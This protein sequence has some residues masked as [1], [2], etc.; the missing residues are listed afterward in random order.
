MLRVIPGG[1]PS[2]CETCETFTGI[3]MPPSHCQ[4]RVWR[5]ADGREVLEL[6]VDHAEVH[7]PSPA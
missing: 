1:G 2:Y 5:R 6:F 7:V 4:G 3:G